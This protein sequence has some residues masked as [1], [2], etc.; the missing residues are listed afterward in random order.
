MKITVFKLSSIFVVFLL[1]SMIIH[2]KP[3][4]KIDDS[5]QKDSNSTK[6]ISKEEKKKEYKTIKAE[7]K[8]I[9]VTLNLKGHFEDPNAVP[10][11]V[12]TKTWSDLKVVKPPTHGKIVKKGESLFQLDLEKI[13]KKI[14]DSKHELS[15]LN[16]NQQILTIEL[17]RDEEINKIELSKLN[18]MEKYNQE[19]FQQFKKIQLPY[20]KKS[21][22]IEL[23]RYE[24]NLSYALEEL[25]QLRKMYE[26]DDLTEETEE[27]II[28]RTQNEV[29]R[30]KFSLEGAMI[31]KEKSL[32]FE[33]PRSEHEKS[34]SFETKK[35]TLQTSRIIKT[36]ELNKKKL[37]LQ[38]LEKEKNRLT[39]AKKKLEDDFQTMKTHS[40]ITGRL[41]VGTFELGKWSGSKLFEPKLK[42]GG[43]LKAFEELITIC[44]MQKIQ[45]RIKIPEKNLLEISQQKDGEIIS[46]LSPEEKI[47]ARVTKISKFPIAPEN[48]DA[49]VQFE[50]P[51]G[52]QIPLPGTT[53]TF[54]VI[55]Y[56][57]KNAITLPKSSVFKEDHDPE[58]KY[59]YIL[60]SKGKPVKKIIETGKGSGSII[61]IVKG[62]RANTEILKEKPD[63]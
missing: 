61:E 20:E 3:A 52:S 29:N 50:I 60:S 11:S 42:K 57:N 46:G 51:E 54:E 27:I 37:E 63:A 53:C 40:P 38:K 62:I 56:Q 13:Q 59:V 19:D 45:A 47:S 31:R 17:K 25:N 36:S 44:P 10:F 16:L 49:V 7:R 21:A 1:S 12:N 8:E 33:I 58:I 55:T 24:E 18:R 32:Q 41:F 39:E 4:E 34:D 23:K 48:Y 26:A 28:Q 22:E 35:V 9:R 43:L 6:E 14:S 30:M 15:L 2:G 5:N